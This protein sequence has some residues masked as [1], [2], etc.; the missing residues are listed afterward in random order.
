M[1][2]VRREI[3]EIV[4]DLTDQKQNF[5][6]LSNC[7]Y[8]ADRAQSLPWPAPTFGSQH[9]K[10]HPN[11]FTFGGVIAGR[12]KAIFWAHW[13]N[14]IYSPRAMHRFG[15]IIKYYPDEHHCSLQPKL[16]T[17]HHLHCTPLYPLGPKSG[18]YIVP[19]TPRGCAAHDCDTWY[20]QT[21]ESTRV[22]LQSNCKS[23]LKS[24]TG[25]CHS[26]VYNKSSRYKT[27]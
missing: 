4:R 25:F 19:L 21:H 9:S 17:V 14:S 2:I 22:K 27:V 10:F 26:T 1:K 13:V 8:C 23:I 16:R 12:V 3:G 20:S 7:R 5:S 15:R 6:S 18:G 24:N 11:R